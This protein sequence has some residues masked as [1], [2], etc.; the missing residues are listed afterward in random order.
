MI[1]LENQ[2]ISVGDRTEPI[3]EWKVWWISEH[4]TFPTFDK[5][6]HHEVRIPTPV[7]CGET[8]FAVFHEPFYDD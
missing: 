7:A 1:D 3:K 2:T 5:V 8:I 4:G 6:S